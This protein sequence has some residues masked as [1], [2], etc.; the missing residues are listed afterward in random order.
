MLKTKNQ[1]KFGGNSPQKLQICLCLLTFSLLLIAR[2]CAEATVGS[3]NN[4]NNNEQHRRR[5][6]GPPQKCP[7]GQFLCPRE[8]TCISGD[9]LA[10]GEPDCEDGAGRH[11]TH[12]LLFY[13]FNFKFKL[14]KF[15]NG[16]SILACWGHIWIDS[17]SIQQK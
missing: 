14:Q 13:V 17:L 15:G 9:Y 10:D 6:P 8:G 11:I 7:L 2:Q 4:N 5:P 12:T 16:I 1:W 3:N